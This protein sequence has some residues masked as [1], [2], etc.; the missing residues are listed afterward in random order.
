[1]AWLEPKGV[2]AKIRNFSYPILYSYK[3]TV[4]SA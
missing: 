1:M 3:M 4:Y 2:E